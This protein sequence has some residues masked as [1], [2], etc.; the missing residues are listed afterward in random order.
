MSYTNFENASEFIYKLFFHENIE[1]P[2]KSV[3][4]LTLIQRTKT[5]LKKNDVMYDINLDDLSFE[6]KVYQPGCITADI[7]LSF[8]N[9]NVAD[10]SAILSQDELKNLLLQRRVTLSVEPVNNPDAATP[11]A[12]SYYVH[13]IIP[14]MVRDSK[15][16]MLFVK[17]N[18]YSTDKLMTLNKYS[19]A[20]VTKRLGADILTSESKIF[21][22]KSQ[23]VKVNTNNMQ[24]LIYSNPTIPGSSNEFIQPY[25]VQ[26]NESFYDFMVRVANRC[27]EFLMFENGQ[28]ILGLPKSEKT[29]MIKNYASISYQNMSA[30]PLTIKAFTRDS[31]KSDKKGEFNDSPVD[32]D[33]TGYPQGTFGTD[34]TYNSELAHDDYIF[35]M[36]RDSFSSFGRVIGMYDA[37]SAI[38]KL[39]LDLFA[40]I[41]SNH[42]DATEGAKAIA[43]NLGAAYTSNLFDA[44]GKA[45][46]ANT[47]GNKQWIDA[48]LT[49]TQ[50]CDGTMTVPFATAQKD[51][52]VKLA[53]YSQIR[54]DEEEQQKKIVHVDMGA[55]LI[56]IKLGDMVTVEKLPG[57]YIVIRIQQRSSNISAPKSGPQSLGSSDLKVQQAQQIDLIPVIEESIN[58]KER[59]M[60]PL[61]DQP[62]IRKSGPQT[63][64]IVDNGDPK[65][66]G[67][68]RIAFP[69][70]AIGDPQQKQELDQANADLKQKKDVTEKAK[71]KQAQ[72]ANLLKLLNAQ[73][74]E[75][76]KMQNELEKEPD[77]QKQKELFMQKRDAIKTKMDTNAARM[78][79]I[80]TNLTDEKNPKSVAGKLKAVND[81][82]QM[83]WY[84][85]INLAAKGAALG[86]LK[87]KE[88]SLQSEKAKL[89]EERNKLSSENDMLKNTG[90][91]LKSFE[92]SGAASPVDFLKQKQE[93][94][95]NQDIAN[96]KNELQGCNKE[97]EKAT[98][99]QS[100]SQAMVDKLTKKWKVQLS[101]VAS[102]WVRMAMPMAT[103]EGGV[104]FR[105]N[106][107]DE[108]M[109]NFDSD[110]VERPYVTGSLYSKEH[111]DPDENMVIKSPSGQ[112]MSF[113]VAKSDKDFVE[114]LTPM[115]AKIGSYI[116]VL[117]GK[118][119]FGKDA[120][121]LCGGITLTDE[122]G[123]FSVDMSSTKRSVS[124]DSPFG[125]VSVNAFTGISIE[126]PN[127]DISIKG[128]NV[129]I[130]A[131]NNLKLLSGTNVT[132]ANSKPEAEGTGAGSSGYKRKQK[133]SVVG[134]WAKAGA[135]FGGNWLLGKADEKTREYLGKYTASFKVVD[136]Q[137]LRCLSDVFLRPIE[138]TLMVKSKNYLMFEAGKGKAE[139][140][141]EQY[142]NEWQKFLGIEKDADKAR[143]YAKT[144]A[145]IKRIDQKVGQFC[146]DYKN[147]MEDAFKAQES[148]ELYI[149]SI[150]KKDS[151]QNA[152]KCL[153]DG[154]KKADKEFKKN[155][156]DFKGG[157]IDM[158]CI[159]Y[160]DFKGQ[161]K[162][163]NF[164]TGLDGE[165]L[166]SVKEVKAYLKPAIEDYGKAAWAVHRQILAFK[167]LFSDNT[168]RAVN[169][170]TLGATSHKE[171]QWIDDAFK[172][173][174]YDGDKSELEFFPKKWHDHYGTLE[175]GPKDCYINHDTPN[176]EDLF[177]DPILIKRKLVAKFLLELYKSDGNLI[178]PEI[179]VGPKKPGKFFKISYKEINFDLL[180]F[181]WSDVAALGSKN[182]SGFFKK[183]LAFVADWT[184]AKKAWNPV[185]N[186]DKPKMGWERRVWNGKGGKIIFSDQKN[187]TYHINGENIETWKHADL[188][189]ESNLKKAISNIK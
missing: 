133:G 71:A 62:V 66:Q 70:Q 178:P 34:Y 14:Q 128:K 146:D 152:P 151:L 29:E 103:E 111:V 43:A 187:V 56:P 77:A 100:D 138:G 89:E 12:E 79:D 57:K 188:G 59:A 150:Y 65:K 45:S 91:T 28:L 10:S 48:Y 25:L 36:F 54:K 8:Q 161:E 116:P 185:L 35:P 16:N 118:L 127:G 173:A 129:S 92:A 163:R 7:Q 137:L 183:L 33:S 42:D 121:M 81:Q 123:M 24:S 86:I 37:T 101:E 181:N 134:R 82:M 126:A 114:S 2:S 179:G 108:V 113:K 148:Y 122:F 18:M 72:V 63:A 22:F 107:G 78:K 4:D 166:T 143:F 174:I 157:T 90:E 120:R 11:I 5:T 88:S 64:F 171:T 141:I 112:K 102:P 105:P 31:V 69:W 165:I 155:D 182:N 52:W 51:G 96:A 9:D 164:I 153:A 13:E 94:I 170:A 85:Y 145:Y 58:N 159:A 135:A 17:L 27:G 169:Q 76:A 6:R 147:L 99:A 180:M 109:V 106:P 61:I 140:G 50:Q 115:L 40:Q 168:I 119:T 53:Y 1:E 3:P 189:N 80:T 32:K 49:K 93:A 104:F 98:K 160:K 131:G 175:S 21:G 55:R 23:L 117:G 75:M 132:D 87:L 110:N 44:K 154:F 73:N 20:Y 125:K 186:P 67:R 142:S 172:K 162:G 68:V 83:H 38:R 124:I 176:Y 136:M 156:D 19:K 30:A 158:S 184:G 167:T 84:D 15:K 130:E 39:S 26:Y 47:A 74:K 149:K 97:V 139:V 144:T 41:V 46:S 95:K 177:M 60:P